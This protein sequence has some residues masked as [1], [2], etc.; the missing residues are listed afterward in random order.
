MNGFEEQARRVRPCGNSLQCDCDDD[1]HKKSK[2]WGT[3]KNMTPH[4]RIHE[5]IRT[6]GFIGDT[7]ANTYFVRG[8]DPFSHALGSRM[9]KC[10]YFTAAYSE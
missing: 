10:W 9:A 7:R 6:K 4:E 3:T 2:K 8:K 1:N 5:W